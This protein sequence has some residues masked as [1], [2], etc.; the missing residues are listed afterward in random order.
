[1]KKASIIVGNVI[2]LGILAGLFFA[3]M[4][5]SSWMPDGLIIAFCGWWLYTYFHYGYLRQEEL[6]HVMTMA[7][8][9]DSPIGPAIWA[10]LSDRPRRGGFERKLEQLALALEAGEPLSDALRATPGLA[11]REMVLAAAVGEASGKLALC[12]RSAPRLRLATAWLEALPRFL[13]PANLLLVMPVVLS[14]LIIFIL[15]KFE[16]IYHDFRMQLPE[17]TRHVIAFRDSFFGKPL[18]WALLLIGIAS[19]ITVLMVSPS[20]RWY[21]PG[22]GRLSRMNVQSR[23]LSMLGILLETERPLPQALDLLADSGYFRAPANQRLE[24]VRQSVERG[25]PLAP[26]LNRQGLLPTRMVPLV[27]T[28]ERTR[29]LPNTLVMLGT[30]LAER[31][32]NVIRRFSMI[33]FPLVVIAF[34]VLIGYIALAWFLPLIKMITELNR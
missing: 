11:P 27:Q 26:A 16:K 24:R 28:A 21:F 18:G 6:L 8:E 4:G 20:A 1:M 7:A 31:A 17:P 10:Y 32:A 29:T 14:F 12:L 19:G 25:D 33:I 23:L 3:L 34:G 9:A 13:Y 5:K 30:H 22:I 2:V 15:P